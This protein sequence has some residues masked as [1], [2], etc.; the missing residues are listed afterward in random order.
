MIDQDLLTEIQYALLEPPDG[1][2][3]WP[4][5]VWSRDEVLDLLN[6]AIYTL[7]RDTHAIIT[8]VEIPVLA[9]SLGVV[10]LPVTWMATVAGVWR[11]LAGVRQPLG[12]GSS[13][14]TDLALPSWETT[15]GT[16]LVLHDLDRA[17]L[18]LKLAPIPDANG[19]LELLYVSR[20]TAVN[21]AGE[22]IGLPDEL[23]TGVKYDLLASLL[24]KAGRLL[25]PDRA[26]YCEGRRDLT[27]AITDLLLK[28]WA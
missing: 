20:P 5:E 24:R 19:T 10:A 4:S 12:A 8:R 3:A 1:G 21:G 17:T 9:A 14:E 26:A 7:H 15:G 11:S 13:H 22:A 23:I 16:P 18:T 25:D 6:T 28:G 27:V 2:Q